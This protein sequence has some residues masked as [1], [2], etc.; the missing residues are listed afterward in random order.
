MENMSENE[1]KQKRLKLAKLFRGYTKLNKEID[2]LITELDM[3]GKEDEDEKSLKELFRNSAF[4]LNQMD[5]L[6]TAD[7]DVFIL[8]IAK[9]QSRIELEAGI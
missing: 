9:K 6:E 4:T 7:R 5:K 1:T 8:R 2:R 3:W